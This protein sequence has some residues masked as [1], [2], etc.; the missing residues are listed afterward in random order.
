MK[1]HIVILHKNTFF[2]KCNPLFLLKIDPPSLPVSVTVQ[3]LGQQ[4]I[5]GE[6]QQ[7]NTAGIDFIARRNVGSFFSTGR[8]EVHPQ[9]IADDTNLS[10]LLPHL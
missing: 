8:D 6:W 2:L 1:I 4:P 5:P 9:Q 3:L 7:L 10:G